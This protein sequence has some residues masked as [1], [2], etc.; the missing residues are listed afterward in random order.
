MRFAMVFPGGAYVV[1]ENG[2]LRMGAGYTSVPHN[3][4]KVFEAFLPQEVTRECSGPIQA[5]W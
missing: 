5:G 3:I 4:R 1:P 2:H